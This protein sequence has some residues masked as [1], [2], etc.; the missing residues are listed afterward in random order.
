MYL[1]LK[2]FCASNG[3]F[4]KKYLTLSNILRLAEILITRG[5]YMKAGRKTSQ[6]VRYIFFL[7]IYFSILVSNLNFFPFSIG[8]DIRV[9]LNTYCISDVVQAQIVSTDANTKYLKQKMLK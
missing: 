7:S 1:I 8:P 9:I 3:Y 6:T 5:F 4:C 2:V